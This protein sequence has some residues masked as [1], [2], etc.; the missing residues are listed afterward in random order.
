MTRLVGT[1]AGVDTASRFGVQGADLGHVFLHRGRLAVLFGDTF[2]G[3]PADPFFSV[4]HR[5]RR[6]STLGWLDSP[7]DV[8][9]G[10]RLAD[11][12]TDRPGHAAELLDAKYRP[13]DEETVIPT[14]GLS[15]GSRMWL[16]YMSVVA[17][18]EPGDWDINFSGMAHSDDDGR[19]WTRDPGAVWPGSTRFGQVA[20]ARAAGDT[21][22]VYGVPAGRFGP[23]S[24]AQVPADRLGERSAYRYLGAHGWSS[25]ERD[26]V[27]VVPA[28]AGELSVGYNSYHGRWLMMYLVETTGEVVLRSA[29]SPTG[30]WSSP[31]VVATTREFPEAYAPAITPVWNDGPDVVFTLSRYRSYGVDLM[32]TRLALHPVG[33]PPPPGCAP[34]QPGWPA[35]WWLHQWWPEATT[36][37]RP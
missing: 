2:G 21:V 22:F 1:G 31:Q 24:L 37:C 9:P 5:D 28:P 10:W 27:D 34:P 26:A 6:G 15:T 3:P 11:M 29:P 19:T 30:P 12:V 35:P 25:D 36:T 14:A 20:Y 33:V 18:D 7:D 17:F 32:R 13:G 16:H 4:P 8:G 23:V